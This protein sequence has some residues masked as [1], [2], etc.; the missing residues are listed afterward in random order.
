MKVFD[1][2][3]EL[4]SFLIL[5]G[6]QSISSLGTAM[7]NFALVIWAYEQK[8]TATSI[9]LLSVCSYL[10]S[11]LFCF[12]AGTLADK[13]NK[14]KIMLVSDFIAAMGTLTVLLLYNTESLQIWHL[15]VINFILSFMNAFQNPA[16]YVAETLITPKEH[17][18]RTSGLQALSGSLVTILHPALATA[19]MSFCGIRAVFIIDLASFAT[20]FSALLFL[21]KIPAIQVNEAKNK[22]GFLRSCLAGLK[23][24]KEHLPVWKIILFFS[25]VNLLASLAGNKIL[26]AMILARTGGDRMI[27][28]TVSSAMGIGTLV[29]SVLVTAV[30]PVRNRTRLIFLS[31]AFSFLLCDVLWGVGRSVPVWV[32]AAFAGNLP[33]PF[34]SANMTTIM[35]TKVPVEM[36]GRVFSTRDTLQYMTIPFGLLFGGI[37]ADNVFEPFMT[38][39]SKVQGFLSNLV[40][41]GKGSGMALIFLVIGIIGFVSN[42]LSLKDP[43]YKSLNE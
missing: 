18:I 43:A 16:S 17:Y 13:W 37:L 5:W 35:R 14:K 28:G 22:E 38:T 20:A 15:Y 24:L 2:L 32:F 7:T 21:I 33:M 12:A 26:P 31:C 4:R 30:G 36:Q 34:I 9:T 8:G 19:V 41:T 42:M 29:G 40:G 25:F 27:L 1:R 10:P 39:A 6:S 23:F 11:I 3:S